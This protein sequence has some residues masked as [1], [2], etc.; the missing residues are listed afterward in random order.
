MG[1]IK[2]KECLHLWKSGLGYEKKYSDYDLFERAF[3]AGEVDQSP[4]GPT[5]PG[6][7]PE[8]VEAM[9]EVAKMK[10]ELLAD[11]MA[12]EKAM[13]N[14]SPSIQ[15]EFLSFDNFL[16]YHQNRDRIKNFGRVHR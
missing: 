13:W 16:A 8:Q 2:S 11:P 14:D 3:L 15:K 7:T 9:E 4:G 5:H 1:I 10:A 6:P 12:R